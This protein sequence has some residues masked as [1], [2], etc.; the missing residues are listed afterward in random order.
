VPTDAEVTDDRPDRAGDGRTPT[1]RMRRPRGLSTRLARLLPPPRDQAL[2]RLF[3]ALRDLLLGTSPAD[4]DPKLRLSA[5]VRDARTALHAGE[6][7]EAVRLAT[8]AGAISPDDAGANNVLWQAMSR[9]GDVS[10]A[11]EVLA[12]LREAGH[13]SADAQRAER[14]LTGRQVETADGWLPTI[15]GQPTVLNNAG[16]DRV[17]HLLKQS[18]PY[19]ETG[20]TIRSHNAL[21]AQRDTGLEPV[22]VT[23]LGFPRRVIPDGGPDAVIPVVEDVD[24]IDHYRLDLGVGYAYDERADLNLIDQARLTAEITE[25]VRPAI[26]QAS[27]GYRG[28]E[29]ALVALALRERYRIPVV[30]EVRGFLEASWTSDPEISAEDVDGREV[31]YTRRRADTE[32]RCMRSADAVITIGE[33][34]RDE[35]VGRGIPRERVHVVPNAVDP[36][37]FAPRD[38]DPSLRQRFG[39]PDGVPVAGYVST[40]EHRRENHELLIAAVASLAGRGRNVVC[41]IVGDGAR[42]AELE[43]AAEALGVRE[44]VIFTGHIPHEMV[45]RLY[46]LLDVFVVPRR[47]DRAARY[48]T[49]LKPFEAMAMEKPIVVTDLP[50]LVELVAPNSPR[51]RGVVVPLDDPEAMASTLESLFDD[52]ALRQRLGAAGR[53][54]VVSERSWAANG[55]RYRAVYDE[56]L[57]ARKDAV[58]VPTAGV[59]SSA[60]G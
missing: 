54:W 59:A 17:L 9:R 19:I 28:Y 40:L 15:P 49:P 25:R 44:R 8:N 10:A 45:A 13:Q 5:I 51:P 56:L 11:L 23:S 37:A 7:D 4:R 20:Y 60:S 52:G 39:V 30:Y 53:E 3:S 48:V 50:A 29:L 16:G 27:S 14:R 1:E 26:I 57:A 18:M 35:I 42:R 2:V 32:L 24:G 38:P 33:A 36:D 21:L 31:E 41:L 12:R 58:P 6:L 55:R 34:M 43:G 46:A 47:E 22:V